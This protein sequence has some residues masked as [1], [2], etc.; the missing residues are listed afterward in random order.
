MEKRYFLPQKTRVKK[1]NHFSHLFKQG[2]RLEGRYIRIVTASSLFNHSAVA[3]VTSKKIGKA[4]CRNKFKR[5]IKEIIR[6]NQDYVK[7]SQDYVFIAK[8][9]IKSASYGTLEQEIISLLI[10]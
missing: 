6:L 10:K 5:K 1:A 4:V 9:W 7:P 3:F 8:P 2:K